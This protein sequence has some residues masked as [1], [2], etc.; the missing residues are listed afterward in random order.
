MMALFTLTLAQLTQR[1]RYIIVLLLAVV[2]I[3]LG[4]IYW[5]SSADTRPEVIDFH[6]AMTSLVLNSAVLPIAALLLATATLGD[7][8]EDNTLGYL[9]LKP[10]P[11]W[12][13]VVPKMLATILG[14]GVPVV[15]S[16]VIMSLLISDGDVGTSLATGA[17]LAVGAA[18]YSV[19]F[20]WGGLASRQAI[21]FGLVYVFL[22]EASISAL[23]SGL[24]FISI[25]QY[26]LGVIRGLDDGRLQDTGSVTLNFAP[27]II[28]AIVV[29]LLFGWLTER[30]LRMMD[31]P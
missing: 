24:R 31:V 14:V 23:F 26:T 27:A 1:R 9:T 11:R 25:R 4:V 2:P 8:V 22:W 16:G 28:G 21:V 6:D 29:V 13:I 19:V 18:A 15:V 5:F 20:T 30:R 10:I 3:L 17:G 7:E 12:Q